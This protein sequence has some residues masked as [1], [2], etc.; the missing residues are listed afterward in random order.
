MKINGGVNLQFHVILTSALD[1]SEG[2]SFAS[3]L[4][5]SQGKRHSTHWTGGQMG[6]RASLNVVVKRKN[7]CPCWEPNPGNPAHSSITILTELPQ[8]LENIC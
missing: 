5:Y 6:S 2:I 3:W 1:G 7:P 4:L 8:L